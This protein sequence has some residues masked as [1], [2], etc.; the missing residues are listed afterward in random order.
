MRFGGYKHAGDGRQQHIFSLEEY[1]KV[2]ERVQCG[3][4]SGGLF[5]RQT[6]ERSG[7]G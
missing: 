3:V 5:H 7:G 1:R 2:K 4:V 6:N